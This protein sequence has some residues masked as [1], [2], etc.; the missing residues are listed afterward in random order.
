[1]SKVICDVCGTTYPETASVCPICG[2][3]KA[4]TV[5]TA[6][7]GSSREDAAGV[8]YVK[9]GRFSKKNVKRRNKAKPV[10]QRSVRPVQQER[11]ERTERPIRQR[12]P[13]K[14]DKTSIGLVIVIILLLISI[15]AVVI[16]IGSHF[17]LTGL[18][19]SGGSNTTTP[20]VETT[21]EPL[22]QIPCRIV[23][24][25]SLTIEFS[26][27]KEGQLLS[28]VT[29]PADTTDVVQFTSSNENVVTVDQNG[30]VT[31]VG[32]GEAIITVKCGDVEATCTVVCSFDP[33]QPSTEPN[34]TTEPPVTV[35]EGFT[36]KLV[37]TDISLFKEGENYALFKETNGVKPSDIT[38]TVDDPNVATVDEN[39]RIY[40]VNR[41]TTT[42]RAEIAGQTATCILRCKFDKVETSGNYVSCLGKAVEDLTLKVGE[43]QM[44]SLVNA[45]GV[46]LSAQWTVDKEGYITIDGNKITGKEVT[47]G[48]GINYVTISCE[49]DGVTYSC[50]I[51]VKEAPAG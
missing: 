1:M 31:A 49:Y 10:A 22:V 6:A 8:S 13:Q 38:W 9:G 42:V 46:R 27:A 36:L 48:T 21:T 44:I 11:T 45:E 26:A 15:V 28:V 34:E 23:Q 4:T 16:Y 51:R 32:G 30:M 12:A 39:G 20:P 5:Q 50:K 3:A 25:S 24:L 2:S 18:S 35:P 29:T 37:Y 7:G 17:F 41:G 40:A 43:T 14:K 47:V 19:N 33:I